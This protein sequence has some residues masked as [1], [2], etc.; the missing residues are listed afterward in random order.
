MFWV[1]S[2]G[3]PICSRAPNRVVCLSDLRTLYTLRYIG[4]MGSIV[5]NLN[6]CINIPRSLV[7]KNKA[8]IDGG[9]DDAFE[10][11]QKCFR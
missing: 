1:G 8:N 7:S 6:V 2:A 4:N 11:R 9:G 3:H 5:L 10:Y